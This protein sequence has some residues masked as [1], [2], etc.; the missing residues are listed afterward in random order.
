MGNLEF[1]VLYTN[2]VLYALFFVFIL[3]RKYE[4]KYMATVI[5]GIFLLSSFFSCMYYDT[6]LYNMLSERVATRS[7]SFSALLYVFSLFVI[8][9][10]PVLTYKKI[11]SNLISSRYLYYFV[12]ILG[13]LSILPMLENL[14]HLLTF[15]NSG[16]ADVYNDKFSEDFDSRAHFSSLGRIC[17]GLT[18]W[19]QYFTPVLFFYIV[20]KYPRDLKVWALSFCAFLNPVLTNLTYGARGALF[21]LVCVLI[22]NY[23]LFFGLF[24]QK[25]HTILKRVGLFTVA[26]GGALLLLV[27][28]MR[29]SGSDSLVFDMISRYMGE[30]FVNFA[31]K[32]WYV[33]VHTDGRSCFNGT[34]FTFMSNFSDFFDSRDYVQLSTIT[35]MRMYVFYTVF[36]DYFIDFGVFGGLFFC[37]LL[38]VC[39]YL[40]VK[41]KWNRLSSILMLNLYAKIGFNGIFHFEYMSRL[42]F[43]MFTLLI[44]FVLRWYENYVLLKLK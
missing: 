16:F 4:G 43:L 6:G 21:Q 44:V 23:F 8:Y 34:G 15:G 9:T 17:N 13:V 2:A 12:L 35:Q 5:A 18:T 28:I 25:T 3:C 1:V 19:F 39:V 31:E 30:G 37:A 33:H 36:G 10:I 14:K 29:Y 20:V 26:G 27:S 22:F 40:F 38:S 11:K 42:E 7:F 24:S 32:G 41:R